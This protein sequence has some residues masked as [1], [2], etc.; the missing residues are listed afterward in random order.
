MRVVRVNY[1]MSYIC[2]V[3]S[4]SSLKLEILVLIT[5]Y[6]EI[7]IREKIENLFTNAYYSTVEVRKNIPYL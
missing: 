7:L 5:V 6:I 4:W 1:V 3:F 2:V